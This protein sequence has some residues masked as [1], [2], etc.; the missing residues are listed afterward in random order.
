LTCSLHRGAADDITAAAGFYRREGGAALARRFLDEFE[1]VVGLLAR[2]PALGTPT[3]DGRRWFPLRGFPYAVIYAPCEEGVRI[4][5]VRHQH[6]A[7]E[8]GSDR[9]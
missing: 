5:V 2:N 6:R 4:L 7:P 8:H 3:R 9:Q 1:R